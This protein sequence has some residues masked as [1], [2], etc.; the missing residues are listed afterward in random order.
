MAFQFESLR[1]W[2]NALDLSVLIRKHSQKF[3]QEEINGLI[4]QINHS[5]DSISLNIAEGSIGG[6]SDAEYKRLLSIAI[7]G[8][9]QVITCLFLAKKNSFID[10]KVFKELYGET[11]SIV[12]QI[13]ALRKSI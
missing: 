2:Q 4:R 7:T 11:E 3:P 8:G 9:I 10:N 6:H 12:V 5:V 13:Q 1:V